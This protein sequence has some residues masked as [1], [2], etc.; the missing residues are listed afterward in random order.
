MFKMLHVPLWPIAVT[1]VLS[2]LSVIYIKSPTQGE[3]NGFYQNSDNSNTLEISLINALIIIGLMVLLTNVLL[4][5]LHL[6]YTAIL[7]GY[8]LV[9]TFLTFAYLGGMFWVILLEQIIGVL[10]IDYFL[11]IFFIWNISA[12][13]CLAILFQINGSN[14]IR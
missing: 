1:M 5:L 4:L 11:F 8:I 10:Q 9:T 14:C 12:T 3:F 2:S 7:K 6:Q 13:G